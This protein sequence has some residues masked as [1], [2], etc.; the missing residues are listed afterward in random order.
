MS[1]KSF[2]KKVALGATLTVSSVFAFADDAVSKAGDV[3]LTALTNNISFSGV[4][5]ALMAVAGSIIT[6]YA[7][8]AGIRWVLRTVKGA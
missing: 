4:L 3:D 1:I 8:F 7:G 5:V 2:C 6:L